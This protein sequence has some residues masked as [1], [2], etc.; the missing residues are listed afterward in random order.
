MLPEPVETVPA[1]L[2][3]DSQEVVA[4]EPVSEP[5]AENETAPKPMSQM[6]PGAIKKLRRV[7]IASIGS[8]GQAG[9]ASIKGREPDDS[10]SNESEPLTLESLNQ[11]WAEMV[12]AVEGELPTL[13]QHLKGL[14]L[15]Q[16][17]DD[18]AEPGTDKG[19]MFVVEVE[20]NYAESEIKPYLLR[21]LTYL[22]NKSGRPMLNCRIEIVM[23][24]EEAV[25]YLPRDKYEVML[26]ANPVLAKLHVFFPD[27][28][29]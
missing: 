5:A 28:D 25:A 11:Y 10:Q 3:E 18:Q 6:E 1:S 8:V 7:S 4:E 26:E 12:H 13:A 15:R 24:E 29:F 21:I 19:D 17:E 23:P 22:R 14:N 16:V 9:P 2:G 27:I 20:S